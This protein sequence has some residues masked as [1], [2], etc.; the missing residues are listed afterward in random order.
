M[1]LPP[2]TID[3]QRQGRF[4]CTAFSTAIAK[5][6]FKKYK[7]DKAVESSFSWDENLKLKLTRKELVF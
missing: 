7:A 5:E 6:L 4:I 3:L 2:T 1:N